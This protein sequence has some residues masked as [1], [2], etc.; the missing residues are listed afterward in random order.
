MKDLTELQKDLPQLIVAL[1]SL[2]DSANYIH[3]KDAKE[4]TVY[5]CPCC[6]GIIKP[7]AYKDDKEYQVQAHYY[8]ENGGCN[9]E[10]FIHYICKM[11]LFEN[12]CKFKVNDQIYTVNN[13]ETE[14]TY[15][16]EFGDYRPDITVYTE[17]NKIFFFEIKNTNKKTENYIPKWDE[18]ENDVVE[19][20]VRYFIN[21]K[22]D[23]NIPEFKLIYSD[24]EC[25]IKTYTRSDY[26]ETI[27]RRKMEWKRQDKLNYKIMWEKLDWFWIEL[28]KYKNNK[29]NLQ[30]VI[31]KYSTLEYGD[32]DLCISIIKKMKCLNL[33]KALIPLINKRFCEIIK[34]YN[35]SPY[36]SVELIQESPRI[37]YI[38]F[39]IESVGNKVYYYD[40]FYLNGKFEYYSSAILKKFIYAIKQIKSTPLSTKDCSHLHEIKE[41]N[42]KRDIKYNIICRIY[43]REREY[44]SVK[45]KDKGKLLY[46]YKYENSYNCFENLTSY[47]YLKRYIHDWR[48]NKHISRRE[49]I[50]NFN[51]QNN[52]ENAKYKVSQLINM[53]NN[54]K[55]KQWSASDLEII[56]TPIPNKYHYG[57]YIIL[58][59]T[60]ENRHIYFNSE[61]KYQIF[62]KVKNTMNEMIKNSGINNDSRIIFL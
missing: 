16:T 3:I 56:N 31:D 9:E 20:D 27:S 6:K 30:N 24:G 12:G 36:K 13:I 19:V 10:T 62:I 39:L 51:K 59:K 5:Y 41:L 29:S 42:Y 55:N 17:E 60:K 4:D 43:M 1:D 2:D 7:R 22:V 49:N 38:G 50:L 52:L 58:N 25:F 21:Q 32:M 53:I 23:S 37:F 18:L 61:N 44:V 8:H 15:H 35:I 28:Q 57:F 33:Y 46:S 40:S 47:Y 11:W 34:A 48:Y 26:E 45:S 54:C 14:K